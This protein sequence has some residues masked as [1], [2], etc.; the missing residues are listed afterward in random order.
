MS[1]ANEL[2]LKFEAN[3]K[4]L[5]NILPPQISTRLKS[6]ELPIADTH[7]CVTILFTDFVGF[8]KRSSTMM[9]R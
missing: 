3:E 2:R 1:N 5:E 6:G 4:L 8:T 9:A 7:E